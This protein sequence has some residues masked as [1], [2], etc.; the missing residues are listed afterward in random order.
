MAYG[1]KTQSANDSEIQLMQF[2]IEVVLIQCPH[3]CTLL[4]FQRR[5][6][7]CG[8]DGRIKRECGNDGRIKRDM[9]ERDSSSCY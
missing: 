7:E 4:S 3:I 8:N 2:C 1:I 5:T 6:R 9:I